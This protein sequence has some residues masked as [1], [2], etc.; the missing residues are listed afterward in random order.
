MSESLD[1]V[2]IQSDRLLRGVNL[3]RTAKGLTDSVGFEYDFSSVMSRDDRPIKLFKFNEGMRS[4]SFPVVIADDD[5]PQGRVTNRFITY[6][7]NGKYFVK[8]G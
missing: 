2:R 6:R 8:V 4:F 7:F 1:V 3:I 5:M